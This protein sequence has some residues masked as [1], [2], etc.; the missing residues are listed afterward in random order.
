[1]N[2]IQ[3]LTNTIIKN[4]KKIDYEIIFVDDNSTD[5]SDKILKLLSKKYNFFKPIFRKKKEILPN[6]VLMVLKKVD[7]IKY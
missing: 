6:R 1:L 5:K 3:I 4:L 2:N 7:I